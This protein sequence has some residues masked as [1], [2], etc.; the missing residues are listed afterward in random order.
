RRICVA[1]MRA[2]EGRQ[3]GSMRSVFTMLRRPATAPPRGSGRARC[4]NAPPPRGTQ[5]RV[6]SSEEPMS[7]DP[8]ERRDGT[9]GDAKDVPRESMAFD[10]VIV[11]AGPAGL[12]AACRLGQLAAEHG[13][14]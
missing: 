14:E 6:F 3:I 1:A 11:G 7:I 5:R 12:A 4:Y 9:L 13:A 10:V 8:A 2:S